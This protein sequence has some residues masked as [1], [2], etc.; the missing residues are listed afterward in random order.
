MLKNSDEGAKELWLRVRQ[1]KKKEH[2]GQWLRKPVVPQ[3]PAQQ[4]WN[5]YRHALV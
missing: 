4:Q 5:A 1:K 3:L 2:V